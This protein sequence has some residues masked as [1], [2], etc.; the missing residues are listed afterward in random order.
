MSIKN[1]STTMVKQEIA[2]FYGWYY[3]PTFVINTEMDGISVN[4]KE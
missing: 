1:T 3:S 4:M 2:F